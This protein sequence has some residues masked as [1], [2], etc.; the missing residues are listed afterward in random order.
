M[1]FLIRKTIWCLRK[2]EKVCGEIKQNSNV[3]LICVFCMMKFNSCSVTCLQQIKQS[4][5]VF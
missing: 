3:M 5:M 1:F 2:T 4:W